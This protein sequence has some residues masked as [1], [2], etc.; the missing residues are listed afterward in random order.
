M[1]RAK[2]FLIYSRERVFLDNEA[3]PLPEFLKF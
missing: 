2:N 1:T 3:S